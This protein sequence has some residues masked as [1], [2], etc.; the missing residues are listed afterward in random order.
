MPTI[1]RI[2]TVSAPTERIVIVPD[3]AAALFRRIGLTPPL[4]GQFNMTELD[5]KLASLTISERFEAKTHLRADHNS[6]LNTLV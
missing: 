5:A 1:A 3:Q 2:D 6:A 4:E